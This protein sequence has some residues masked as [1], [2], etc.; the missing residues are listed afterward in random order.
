[1]VPQDRATNV[2]CLACLHDV[3]TA[4]QERRKQDETFD[5]IV[6]S[7]ADDSDSEDLSYLL[8]DNSVSTQSQQSAEMHQPETDSTS[9][10]PY[11]TTRTIARFAKFLATIL[12]V[13]GGICVFVLVLISLSDKRE[14]ATGT[15]TGLIAGAL[16]LP[17][18]GVACLL[19][20]ESLSLAINVAGQIEQIAV[21]V[22]S[23]AKR[24]G[25]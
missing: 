3:R 10:D 20:S 19:A 15:V 14:A 21:D 2:M 18:S 4:N 13:A 16:L 17:V 12:F 1:M 6:E 5:N 9:D 24:K 11:V 22:R 8:D 7:V 25:R 23:L